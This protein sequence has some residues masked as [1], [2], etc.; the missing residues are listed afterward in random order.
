[1]KSN[2]AVRVGVIV[3]FS[4]LLFLGVYLFLTRFYLEVGGYK[5]TVV[6]TDA[7]SLSKGSS[8]D[9]A[10]VDIGTVDQVTLDSHQRAI[11]LLR[12]N[13]QYRIPAGSQFVLR[14]GL[15]VGEKQ[16][17]IIPNRTA[18]SFVP[19]GA[20]IQGVQP[21]KIEDLLPQGQKLLANLT[22]ASET[23]KDLVNDKQMHKQL[24]ETF[25]HIE[26]ASDNLNKTMAIIQQTTAGQQSNIK[27]IVDNFAATSRNVRTTTDELS[28]F[29]K[30]GNVQAHMSEILTSTAK[31]TASMERT[32]ASLEKLVTD[33]RFQGD[34]R[35]TVSETRATVENAHQA[36]TKLNKVL[37]GKGGKMLPIKQTSIEGI[38]R[39]SDSR[40]RV[41]ALASFKTG[42]DG[43]F[44][45]GIYDLGDGNKLVLQPG[46]SITANT[47]F[48]YGLYASKLG[49][50]LD[51]NFSHKLSGNAN[52]YDLNSPNL[53]ILAQYK[54]KDDLGLLMGVDKLFK[55]NQLTMGVRMSK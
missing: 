51:H 19:D 54:I 14:V 5:V 12:I 47:D 4:I 8:V 32:T 7:Q 22:E 43:F 23:L 34:I 11:V 50:G 17:D 30:N 2:P 37:G 48:R 31:T 1:M 20:V 52:L 15:L 44:N 9:M 27:E 16:I 25:D 13:K 26:Q 29:A 24:K 18:T 40:F 39:P 21:M 6:F 41:D 55:D 42:A 33:P 45:M 46:R 10:G 28:R 36:L 35:N 38:Y 53:D 49:V 3:V